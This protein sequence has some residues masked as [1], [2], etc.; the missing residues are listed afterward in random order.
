VVGAEQVAHPAVLAVG[1]A[2]PVGSLV[3]RPAGSLV[4]DQLDRSHLIKTDDHPVLGRLA[5]QAPRSALVWKSGSGL[6][7]Q[8]RVRWWESPAPISVWR[9]ASSLSK[10]PIPARC[11]QSLGSDQRVNATP[12]VSGRARAHG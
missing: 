12:W 6:H 7:F 2:Q 1:R 9:S 4:G 11:A 8:E 3:L 5:V 10:I